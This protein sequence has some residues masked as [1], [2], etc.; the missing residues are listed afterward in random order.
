MPITAVQVFECLLESN[1]SCLPA[2]SSLHSDEVKAGYGWMHAALAGLLLRDAT[3]R[4]T[5][6]DVVAAFDR[7]LAGDCVMLSRHV[8]SA[9]IC[10]YR[11]SALVIGNSHY[12][13]DS[14]RCPEHD[15]FRMQQELSARG[16]HVDVE[17]DL[18]RAGIQQKLSRFV[19]GFR[20]RQERKEANP[21][22]CFA[23][24]RMWHLDSRIFLL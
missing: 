19:E 17:L 6:H 12:E 4:S 2:L 9:S 22:V 1:D 18:T 3:K 13:C 14:L 16:F 24:H 21:E 10:V 20:C 11:R 5:C 7:M 23:C 15:A 8:G